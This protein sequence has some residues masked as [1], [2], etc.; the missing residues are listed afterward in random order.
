MNQAA[1]QIIIIL[2]IVLV[3]SGWTVT[4]QSIMDRDHYLPLGGFI[5]VANGLIS[6]LNYLDLGEYHK[7][8][9]FS[10]WTGALLIVI[11]LLVFFVFHFC[12]TMTE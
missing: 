8:H 9:D 3:A 6:L 2:L 10:G 4:Y 7:F 5:I 1:S 12:T 11:R